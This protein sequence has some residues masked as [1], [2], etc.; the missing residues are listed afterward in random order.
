MLITAANARSGE[1][2]SVCLRP[3]AILSAA[4]LSDPQPGAVGL[5]GG[6]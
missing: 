1:S 4:G 2:V 5:V 6:G 3:R